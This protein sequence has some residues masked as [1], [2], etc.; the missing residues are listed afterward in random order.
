[1]LNVVV[2]T[3]VFISSLKSKNGAS[4]QLLYKTSRK[5]YQQ[6]ISSTLVFE[7]ESVAKRSDMNLELSHKQID[8]IIDMLCNWSNHCGIYFLWRPFLKDAKDDFVLELAIESNSQYIITYN[9]N[10]FKGIDKF[11]IRAITPK[12]FLRLLGELEL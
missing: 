11:N 7:Y 2:D 8:S 12:E 5:K 4:F 9:V 6:N 3:N 10:D 1:M